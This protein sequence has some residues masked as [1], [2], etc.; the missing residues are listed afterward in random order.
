MHELHKYLILSYLLLYQKK[1]IIHYMLKMSYI[2]LGFVNYILFSISL[3]LADRSKFMVQK[4]HFNSYNKTISYFNRCK[5]FF[6]R[7]VVK[8][9]NHRF[10]NSV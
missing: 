7:F 4:K 9:K 6:Y 3:T 2:V 5:Y 1:V 10:F 8:I